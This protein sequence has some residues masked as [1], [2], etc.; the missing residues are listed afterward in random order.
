MDTINKEDNKTTQPL[1]ARSILDQLKPFRAIPMELTIELGRGK[2]R[3][4]DLLSLQYHS[5]FRL[6]QTAGSRLNVLLNGIPLAK[7]EPVVIEERVGIKIDEIVDT[8]R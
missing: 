8:E 1:E 7:G 3:L 2:L 6:E 5:V 4:R